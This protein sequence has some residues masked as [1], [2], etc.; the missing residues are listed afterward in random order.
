MY[1]PACG[2]AVGQ[3][4]SYCNYCGAKL[5]GKGDSLARPPE[6]RPEILAAAMVFTFVGGLCAIIGLMAVMKNL[7]DF[8]FGRIMAV[9]VLSFLFMLLLEAVFIWKFLR[10]RRSPHETSEPVLVPA[11]ATKELN[12]TQ[13]R[14]L[15][16]PLPSVT[17]NTTRAFEPSYR[18][19][20]SK[21]LN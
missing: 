7:P 16:D 18:E 14:A 19:R 11:H 20:T 13:P 17:E 10:G 9:T 21:D 15:P 12:A 6:V 4:L 2:V 5:G 3:G 8:D 1:C